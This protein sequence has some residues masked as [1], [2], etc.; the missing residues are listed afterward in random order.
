MDKISLNFKR[1]VWIWYQKGGEEGKESTKSKN[2]RITNT[3]IQHSF[4]F[5]KT[6]LSH[7]TSSS[8]IKAIILARKIERRAVSSHQNKLMYWEGVVQ[9]SSNRFFGLDYK[10]LVLLN[11]AKRR[12]TVA[13]LLAVYSIYKSNY[14]T[15]GRAILGESSAWIF[16]MIVNERFRRVMNFQ[17]PTPSTGVHPKI[18]WFAKRW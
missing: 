8:F 15:S 11:T 17:M 2:H 16:N 1:R 6:A 12:L 13:L 5:K 14:V 4:A 10:S 7:T 9:W 18:I 3:L